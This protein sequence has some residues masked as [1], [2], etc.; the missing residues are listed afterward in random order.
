MA[1]SSNRVRGWW[2]LGAISSTMS[3]TAP[4]GSCA[5]VAVPGGPGLPGISASSP[6]PNAFLC[7]LQNLPGQIPI[8]LRA[9]AVGVIENDG[10]TERRRF[11]QSD[12]PRNH[13]AVDTFRKE[14]TS[15]I[16]HLL[17]KIQTRVEH[18]E[19]HS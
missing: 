6:L 2:G 5:N 13:A 17:R 1:C 4:R 3:S 10:L 9:G 8:T 11:A 15:F 19:E 16:R 14:L 12:I 7:M 18:R